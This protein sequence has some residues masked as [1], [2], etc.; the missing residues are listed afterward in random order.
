MCGKHR[1]K[2]WRSTQRAVVLSS[3]DAEVY[4]IIETF[5]CV[6]GVV[7]V[8]TEIGL[9]IFE[10]IQ[11][12]TGSSTAKSFVSRQGLGKMKHLEIHDL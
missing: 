7:S 3:A 5:Y 9:V 2:T 4:L 6:K 8:M 12:Y 11:L 1:L 10:V